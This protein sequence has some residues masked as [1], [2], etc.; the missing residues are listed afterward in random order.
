MQYFSAL[1]SNKYK[2]IARRFYKKFSHLFL[3]LVSFLIFNLTSRC[4]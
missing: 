3:L 4:Y 1:Y 2:T